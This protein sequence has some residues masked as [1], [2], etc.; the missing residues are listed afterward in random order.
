MLKIN[1]F[2]PFILFFIWAAEI[3]AQ[4]KPFISLY[5]EQ[6]PYF[7]ELITGGQYG[8]APLNYEG[9][10]YFEK[11][12]FEEGL[13]SIN[14][15][16]YSDVQLLYDENADVVVTFHPIY[17]QKI[18]IKSEKVE[19]F[20]LDKDH[21][22]RRFEGNDSYP[23]HNNG[24]YQV[25]KDGEIKVLQKHYK[26]IEATKEVGKYPY[27][28]VEDNE[29]FYWFN[30]DFVPIR[31]KKQAIQSLGL[32]K[33]EVKKHMKQMDVYFALEKEEYILEL[34]DF[35]ESQVEEFKG[36]VQ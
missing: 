31:K 20:Q 23:H 5:K 35:R 6:L 14:K 3:S 22:F 29:Y 19:E 1:F 15:I 34:A 16:D 30:G 33:R 25:K 36:F 32:N 18:L 28:F 26:T 9:H 8:E 2:A 27:K 21:V 24:F 17:K 10:P 4:S 7:Q 12:V 11:R 13:L